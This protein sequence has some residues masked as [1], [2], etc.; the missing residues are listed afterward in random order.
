MLALPN[1]ALQSGIS[2]S[3]FSQ[4]NLIHLLCTVNSPDLVLRRLGIMVGKALECE[5]CLLV[6]GSRNEAPIY[7]LLWTAD[8][9]SIRLDLRNFWHHSWAQAIRR[10]HQPVIFHPIASVTKTHD[11]EWRLSNN[12][13]LKSGIGLRTWFQDEMNGMIVIGSS[14]VKDWLSRDATALQEIAEP[15]ALAHHL[16]QTS[17]VRAE[18]P[19]NSPGIRPLPSE[20]SPIVK[21][22]YDA[23]RQKLEQQRQW[24]E[25]LLHNIVTI[26][27]DQTRNPLATIRMGLEM[28]RTPSSSPEVLQRRLDAMEQAWYKLNEINTKILQLRS[29][30]FNQSTNFS[31]SILLVPWL[32]TQ[33]QSVSKHWQESSKKRLKI[34]S[35]FTYSQFLLEANVEFLEQIFAELLTNAEKFSLPHTLVQLRVDVVNTKSLQGLKIQCSNIG[36]YVDPKNLKYFFDPFYRAQSA[37]DTAIAGIGLGLTITKT[38]VEQ[39]NG[40]IEVSSEPTDIP[41]RC[42]I[43]FTLTLPGRALAS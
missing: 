25:Q 40:T 41:H 14:E 17:Y 35:H 21:L 4:Q 43:T 22:W 39:L 5:I 38:L 1:F 11:Q 32:E 7:G 6:V 31:Q 34:V 36:H 2:S 10:S 29:L 8:G 24:N 16:L 9:Q 30:K 33:M 23:T 37:I 15:M 13:V 28:L 42:L 12:I 20:D 26:M 19:D 3:M 27:S 18:F